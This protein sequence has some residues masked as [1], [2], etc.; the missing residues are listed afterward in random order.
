MSAGAAP[1]PGSPRV[2]SAS[3]T[4]PLA[5]PIASFG[6]ASPRKYSISALV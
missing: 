4:P 1:E 2:S 5:T 3:D 6:S